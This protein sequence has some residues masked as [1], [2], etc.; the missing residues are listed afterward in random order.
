MKV[1]TEVLTDYLNGKC[2]EET[3]QKLEQW[4]KN[5]PNNR[6]YL[7]ELK[8]YWEAKELKPA[9][10]NFDSTEGFQSLLAKKSNKKSQYIRKTLRYAA[11]IAAL[12]TTSLFGYFF[13]TPGNSNR[14]VLNTEQTEKTMILPDGT[15]ILLAIGSS[16]EYP[17]EFADNERLVKLKGEAFFNVTKNEEKPFVILS[18]QTQTKV[19]G[20]SFRI[21]EEADRTMIKVRTGIVEFMQLG[22][23]KNKIRLQK[24]DLA[25]FVNN[26]KAVLKGDT[27]SE[28]IDFSVKLLE[29]QNEKLEIICKDLSELFN[30]PIQIQSE[31]KSQLSLTAVFENQ[32]IKSIIESICFTLNL[33]F[34]QKGNII[35]LK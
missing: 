28:K 9:K 18:G 10:I 35:L 6:K 20:T 27:E 5:E 3:K 2:D 7:N 12:V 34:E 16:I 31:N 8:V 33:E 13:I 1:N 19:V 11:F 32:N 4:L 29:Y 21:I 15:S 23:P 26:Q 22:N 17:N 14:I 24:G 30:T 25:L